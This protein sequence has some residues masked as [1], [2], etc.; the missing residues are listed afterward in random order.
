MDAV[1]VPIRSVIAVTACHVWQHT[2]NF[3]IVDGDSNSWRFGVND[4]M[5]A[6]Q[7]VD[8]SAWQRGCS[9]RATACRERRVRWSKR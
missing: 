1:D 3:R 8:E 2:T 4:A 5:E 6:I 7:S 9:T